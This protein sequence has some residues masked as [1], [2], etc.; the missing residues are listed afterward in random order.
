MINKLKN[1]FKTFIL[2]LFTTIIGASSLVAPVFAANYSIS[3][4]YQM[5]SL[6]PGESYVGNFEIV[7]PG[8]NS[9]NF[10]YQLRVE[11]FTVDEKDSPSLEASG[12]YN[13]ITDW[14][15]LPQATGTVA[16]N[17]HAEARFVINVPENAPAGGQYFSI[18]ISSDE[19]RVNNSDVD[20]RE[21]YET[22]HLVY[23]DIAG[24]TVRK[25]S[26]TDVNIPSF[27]F[28]GNIS[29][30]AKITN[31]GNVHSVASQTLQIFPLFSKEEV[32]TNEEN[33]KETLVLPEKSLYSTIVWDGTP[34]VGIFHVIYNVDYEGVDSN[35]D[36]YVIVCPLW[37]LFVLLA[38]LFVVI[39]SIIFGKKKSQKKA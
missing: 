35:V 1:K 26:V 16:P 19:Y 9:T 36:K 38:C 24:E 3:P 20:L 30:S 8:D 4:M 7:N 31:E 27:L 23:A 12:N 11:P 6:T 37:L 33:P 28:S 5:V 25:G 29:A 39:F 32:F 14:V 22:A 13:Q 10:N 17:Q 18:V 2:C 21:I 15:E 34:S